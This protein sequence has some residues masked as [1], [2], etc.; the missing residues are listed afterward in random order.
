[1][2]EPTDPSSLKAIAKEVDKLPRMDGPTIQ[3][4]PSDLFRKPGELSILYHVMTM[5]YGLLTPM[6]ALVGGSVGRILWPQ[7]SFI[8]RVANGGLIAGG[9]GASMGVIAM[10]Q[11]AMKGEDASPPWNEQGIQQRNQGLSH[12]Y[13]VR[14]MDRN[15]WAGIALAG[16]GVVLAGGPAQ[17]G[18][19]AGRLGVLQALSLGSSAGSLA[20]FGQIG[21]NE[22]QFRKELDSYDKNDDGT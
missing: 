5:P 19:A 13:K 2:S 11:T 10:T 17:I 1:M 4:T 22:Y 21:W 20:A 12:N 6:G 16:L 3:Y 8:K 14:V 9:F 7:V 15:V 18:L